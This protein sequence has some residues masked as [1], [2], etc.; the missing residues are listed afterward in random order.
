VRLESSN[1]N[2]KPHL[3]LIA[4]LS[5]RERRLYRLPLEGGGKGIATQW[6]FIAPEIM[7]REDMTFLV[8]DKPSA[9]E[10]G[11]L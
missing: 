3:P 8:Q 10:Q 11:N 9:Q 2:T 4:V 5:N 7:N 6:N 1:F